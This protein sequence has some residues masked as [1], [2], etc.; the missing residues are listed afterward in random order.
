MKLSEDVIQ[1]LSRLGESGYVDLIK[2]FED[3]HFSNF[4][5]KLKPLP[6]RPERLLGQNGLIYIQSALYRSY[7]LSKGVV[8]SLNNNNILSG[9]INVRAHF[10]MTGALGF[11]LRKLIQFYNNEISSEKF[12]ECLLRLSLGVKREVEMENVPAPIN[13]MTMIDD[14]DKLFKNMSKS[15]EKIFRNSY[16]YL[17]EYCHPNSFGLQLSREINKVGVVRFKQLNNPSFNVKM[18]LI[19]LSSFMVTSTSFR[20]FY[21]GCRDRLEKNEDLPIKDF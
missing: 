6:V 10:E 21:Q 19:L 1:E 20:M 2:E 18:N 3:F 9:L 12:N 4:I 11:L 8:D 16:D 7:F 17:S 14:A 13:V 5:S 15:K